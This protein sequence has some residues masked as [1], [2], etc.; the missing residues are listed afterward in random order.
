M[1]IGGGGGFPFQI[2]GGLTEWEEI[3]HA[4]R[5][6]LGDAAGPEDGILDTWNQAE[7]EAIYASSLVEAAVRQ[8]LPLYATTSLPIWENEVFGDITPADTDQERREEIHRRYTSTSRADGPSLLT[9]LQ[10]I[11][12]GLNI[13]SVDNATTRHVMPGRLFGPWPSRTNDFGPRLSSA[14]GQFDDHAV[15]RVTYT[16]KSGESAIPQAIKTAVAELMNKALP[17]NYSYELSDTGAAFY[18]DGFN[19]SR[20]DQTRIS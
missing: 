12:A 20:M 15:V 13:V 5:D 7:T 16:L 8:W 6:C 10:L 4:I 1:A 11:D 18:M 2:G 17:A 19:N 9:D 14:V 3:Y